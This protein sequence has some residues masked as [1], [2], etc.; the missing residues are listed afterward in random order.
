M[1]IAE[2]PTTME[3]AKASRDLGLHVLM[4]APNVIR[5]GSHSGN[6]AAHELAAAGAL[7]IFLLI[8]IQSVYWMPFLP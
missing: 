4:G 2:F 7:D 1:V 6:I 3:A 5:G 8:I